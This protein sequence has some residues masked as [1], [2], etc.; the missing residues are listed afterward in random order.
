MGNIRGLAFSAT[1]NYVKKNFGESGFSQILERLPLEQP[2]IFS[3]KFQAMQWY[4]TEA[5]MNFLSTTEEIF[6]KGDYHLCYLIGKAAAEEAF[7]GLYRML[8]EMGK[9]QTII[10]RGPLAWRLLFTGGS[11]ELEE[12]CLL[13]TSPSPR[14]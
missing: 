1:V 13:Y 10:K 5:L 11:F 14:D 6:G 9:P 7:G 3:E 2:Q 12:I 8:L 4:P